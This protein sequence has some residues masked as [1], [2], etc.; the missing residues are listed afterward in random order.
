MVCQSMIHYFVRLRLSLQML[1]GMGVTAQG[2]RQGVVS[3]VVLSCLSVSWFLLK[4]SWVVME[5]GTTGH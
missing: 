3:C 1:H 5:L 4:W 2:L